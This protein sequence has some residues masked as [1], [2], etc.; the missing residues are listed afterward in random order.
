MKK[1]TCIIFSFFVLL[2]LTYADK[3]MFYKNGQVID[4]AYVVPKE[5]LN[6]RYEPNL[7]SKKIVTLAYRH[8]Q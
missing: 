6:A 1:A 5:G 8:S 3:S 7:N 4:I 2:T